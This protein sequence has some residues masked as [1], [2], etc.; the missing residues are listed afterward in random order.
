VHGVY[1]MVDAAQYC[2]EVCGA[3]CSDLPARARLRHLRVRCG[4]DRLHRGEEED[5][6]DVCAYSGLRNTYGGRQT[7]WSS[8]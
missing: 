8:P 3:G 4:L 7:Y 2:T 6:L 5:L 1:C